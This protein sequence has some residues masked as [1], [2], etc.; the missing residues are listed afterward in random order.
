MVKCSQLKDALG[1][2]RC[3]ED[4]SQVEMFSISHSKEKR[5]INSK[6]KVIEKHTS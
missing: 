5:C 6:T 2:D 1:G 4:L 3:F